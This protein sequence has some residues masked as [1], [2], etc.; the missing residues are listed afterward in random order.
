MNIARLKSDPEIFYSLQGEGA[1]VG[2]PAVFL[3]LAGCN[4]SCTWCDTKH[5]WGAG[6]ELS[7]EAV[8]QRLQ[9]Y[10]CRHLVITGGE[11]LLQ[12][13]EL[14]QLLELLP[15]D[16]VIE[17]ETNGSMVPSRALRRRVDWWNVSPKLRHSGNDAGTAL[18]FDALE[19]FAEL[20]NVWFKFVVQGEAD[21]R[22]IDALELPQ[23]QIMLMPCASTRAELAAARPAVAEMCLQHGVRLGERL[24]LVLWDTKKGV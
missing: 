1:Q 24:H 5:S 20:P 11:P 9:A 15:A 7:A 22:D 6:M 3:R 14:E 8:A 2:T 17:I 21:W 19:T 13:E 18:N 4:L 12:Q 10:S 23:H 16:Y